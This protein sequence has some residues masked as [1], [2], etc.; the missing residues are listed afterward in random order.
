MKCQ[1]H[2]TQT[3]LHYVSKLLL[4]FKT[5][6]TATNVMTFTFQSNSVKIDTASG[7]VLGAAAQCRG[8]DSGP[9]QFAACLFPLHLFRPELSCQVESMKNAIKCIYF[10]HYLCNYPKQRLCFQKMI[11]VFIFILTKLPVTQ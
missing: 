1:F 7:R 3:Y 11:S 10:D 4:T 5:K 9:R 6:G 2:K 8:V